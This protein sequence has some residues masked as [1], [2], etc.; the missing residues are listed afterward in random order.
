[1]KKIDNFNRL[2]CFTDILVIYCTSENGLPFEITRY[3]FQLKDIYNSKLISVFLRRNLI[4]IKEF[5]KLYSKQLTSDNKKGLHCVIKIL[6][7][8]VIEEKLFIIYTFPKIITRIKELGKNK[9][10]IEELTLEDSIFVK[11]FN[12]F[13]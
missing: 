1:M 3:I 13:S 9:T 4:H 10:L 6:I 12:Q 8:L 7:N 11:K 5:D 2:R